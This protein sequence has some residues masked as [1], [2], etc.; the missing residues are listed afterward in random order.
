MKKLPSHETVAFVSN[1]TA[2][3]YDLLLSPLVGIY[4]ACGS[5]KYSAWAREKT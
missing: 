1:D 2:L 3:L 4:H 5:N